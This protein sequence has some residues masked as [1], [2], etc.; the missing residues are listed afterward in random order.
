MGIQGFRNVGSYGFTDL[1]ING[2]R[3]LGIRGFRYSWIKGFRD[4]RILRDFK[5]FYGLLRDSKQK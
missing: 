5:G 2:F 3:D 1:W 4:L